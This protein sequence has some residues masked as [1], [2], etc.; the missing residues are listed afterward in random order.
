MNTFSALT[1]LEKTRMTGFC[2]K[3]KICLATLC[4]TTAWQ[5]DRLVGCLFPCMIDLNS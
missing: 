3:F 5:A 2:L 1:H 4:T